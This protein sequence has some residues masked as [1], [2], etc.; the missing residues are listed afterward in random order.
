[1]EFGNPFVYAGNHF[2]TGKTEVDDYT[3]Y[4]TD[5]VNGCGSGSKTVTLI[6][7]PTPEI[8][9]ATSTNES[10][11][12]GNDGTITIDA[13]DVTGLGLEYSIDGGLNF[14]ANNYFDNLRHGNYPVIV[15]NTYDCEIY[16]DTLVVTAGENAP[17]APFAG[18]KADYCF[19]ETMVDL[20]AVVESGGYLVWY[21]DPLLL[22]SIATGETFVIPDTDSIGTLYIYVTQ[23]NDTCEGPSTNI[24]IIVNPNPE[25]YTL[26]GD[27]EYCADIN[28]V[29]IELDSSTFLGIN[30][31]LY[32]DDAVDGSFV[33]GT[34]NTISWQNNHFGTYHIIATDISSGCWSAMND[35]LTV[36]KNNLPDP[37]FSADV[38]EGCSPLS[39]N[40]NRYS[41]DPALY[42][43]D[44]GDGII[45]SIT[46]DP[47][48]I[49]DNSTNFLKYYEVRLTA[50]TGK[51][52][53]DS[54]SEYIT[55]FP[56]PD[57]DFTIAPDSACHPA[58]V[59]LTSSPGGSSYVW[60]FGNGPM[61]GQFSVTN[62]FNNTTDNDIV[63][64]IRLIATS[65]FSC[66]D[67]I[68]KQL[69]VFPKP[70][71]NFYVNPTVGC[72]PH[73]VTIVNYS[74]Q[75]VIN[76]YWNYGD[77][78]GIDTTSSP[79]FTKMYEN[80]LPYEADYELSL[81]VET[82]NGCTDES[83]KKTVKVYPEVT[84]DFL[85]DVTSGCNPLT[86]NLIDRSFGHNSILNYWDFGDGQTISGPV[87]SHVFNNST[88]ADVIYPVLLIAQSNYNC[89]D[90]FTMNVAVYPSPEARFVV[91]PMETIYPDTEFEIIN[92]SSSGSWSYGWELGDGN[93]EDFENTYTHQYDTSGSY[94]IILT[95]SGEHCTDDTSVTVVVRLPAPIIYIGSDTAGCAPLTVQFTNTTIYAEKYLWDFGDG[96]TSTKK[97][98]SPYTYTDAGTYYVYLLAY[99]PESFTDTDEPVTIEVYQ[100]P[101]AKFSVVSP[102]AYIP[103][104]PVAVVNESYNAF[105]YRWIFDT[106]S[107]ITDKNTVYYFDEPGIYD[108]TLI[109]YSEDLCTDTLLKVSAVKVE[110]TGGLS[111][112]N[113]FQ[114]NASSGTDGSYS[115]DGFDRSIFFPVLPKGVVKYQ[116]Q[117]FN[118]WGE[119][120]FETKDIAVGWNGR[121]LNKGPLCEQD[122]Y[123]WKATVTYSDGRNSTIVGD[124]TLLR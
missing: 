38:T 112:M 29:T 52:C 64:P 34:G 86:I 15:K 102:V 107:S 62:V 48:H 12:N 6:I 113:A 31:Q 41:I 103:D 58:T 54:V 104:K 2:V 106:D 46:E 81:I 79:E 56:L 11:C 26:T 70:E 110:D 39:V 50:V 100:N 14:F 80:L 17:N 18:E 9:S 98:P 8:I 55:V 40:F 24:Q 51:G 68:D 87:S 95:V 91:T 3:Y 63:F 111:F 16:G 5:T 43:W 69:V 49:F 116:L 82:E 59:Q 61:P 94:T 72:S 121:Y 22:D 123:F 83:D 84:A 60:D 85:P 74:S 4:V 120:M 19:G 66:E 99:G 25:I 23:K 53:R 92:A 7:N 57:Y 42:I 65:A 71:A 90:S 78:S 28:G 108:I 105:S 44:F 115:T 33:E 73:E 97:E 109:A 75:N 36:I 89:V 88:S 76:Y 117:I 35:T 10:F 119:I 30:Y 77:N 32:K 96:G 93:T 118:R 114:P 20:T 101:V 122:V 124:I 1:N 47:M 21:S 27:E 37:T 67:T 13:N 45:D